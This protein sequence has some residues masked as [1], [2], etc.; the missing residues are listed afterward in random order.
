MAWHFLHFCSYNSTNSRYKY[1][2]TC[3][4][5]FGKAEVKI[6]DQ[7][8]NQIHLPKIQ[9]DSISS[10]KVICICI[11]WWMSADACWWIIGFFCLVLQSIYGRIW[12]H[13]QWGKKKD[14]ENLTEI[15][16]TTAIV[17]WGMAGLGSSA[18]VNT[19]SITYYSHP[20]ISMAA[21]LNIASVVALQRKCG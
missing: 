19:V 14:V 21:S 16:K 11:W 2:S 1:W 9:V 12:Q 15:L 10:G 6:Q 18:G 5:Y 4:I 13:F 20:N 8:Q 17:L 3:Y 7:R